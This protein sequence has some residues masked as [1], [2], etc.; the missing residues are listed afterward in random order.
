MDI[1]DSEILKV[2]KVICDNI[3]QKTVLGDELLSQNIISQ[4]RN[5]VEA[6]AIKIYSCTC[7]TSMAKEE[8][9]KALQYIKSQDR[10]TF[11]V[12]F[13]NCLQLTSSHTTMD[14]EASLRLMWKYWDYLYECRKFI[15]DEYNLEVLHNLDDFILQHD[16]TLKEYYGEIIKTLNIVPTV[17]ITESPTNR[18]YINKKKPVFLNGQR[19]YELTLLP[20]DDMMS[21]SDRIIAF[22]KLNV[23]DYYAVHLRFTE[24]KISVINREMTI[25]I[26][27]GFRVSVR[28][29]EFNNYFKIIGYMTNIET[30]NAE[31]R[32]LMKYM[33]L[34]GIN[35][36]EILDYSEDKFNN[37]QKQLL[38]GLR[39]TPIFIGL[40]KCREFK[41]RDGYFVLKYLLYRLNNQIIKDQYYF[42]RNNVL[43][44]LN[45]K[46]GCIP[47]DRMPFAFNLIAHPSAISDLY[48]CFDDNG[49]AHELLARAIKNNTEIHAKLYTK[50]MDLTRFNELNNLIDK[51]NSKLYD[52]HK[53]NSCLRLQDG[54]VYIEGYEK[55]TIDIIKRLTELAQKGI[56]GYTESVE[57]WLKNS[58]Y[59][60][61]SEEKLSVLKN[62]FTS[63]NVSLIYGSAGTG[64]STMINHISHFFRD[65][66]RLYLANTHAAVE[67]LRRNVIGDLDNFRTI[68]DCL[69]KEPVECDILFVDECSTVS[70]QDMIDLLK[71]VKFRLLVLVGDIYQIESIKFGNWFSIAR[72]YMPK[73]A[74]YELSYVHRSTD[75]RLKELWKSVRNLDGKMM[76]HLE[77]NNYCTRMNDSIFEKKGDDEI[78]L[79]LNYD[80]LYGINNINK[81]L[82][83]NNKGKSVQIGIEK[84]K[85]GDPIIFKETERFKNL[86]YNNL[87]GT[88][89][90]I[91]E[92]EKSVKFTTEIDKVLN[93]FNVGNV[94]VELERPIH[95]GKSVISFRIGKFVNVDD[96]DRSA[97]DIIPF[98]VAY[99]ISIHKAQGLEYDSVKIVISDEMDKL[100]THNIFYTAITRAKNQLKIY[101]S[102]STEK[103]I[104]QSMHFMF[105]KEDATI[106]AKKFG[107]KLVK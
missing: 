5:F 4:L 44:E 47:F 51:F 86:L 49:R 71:F 72:F 18:F 65:S 20:A 90:G 21:K 46:Y 28:P 43:S 104:L 82:Q 64:K 35:L 16:D 13:H 17:E 37:I 105:N 96:E 55:N 39:S 91:E 23:P 81:F 32:E 106:L 27:T 54:F 66:S 68:R 38:S 79:C 94:S 62:L 92:D 84:F 12:R 45:L 88:I 56:G 42:Q 74:V 102:E 3:A 99:A 67:N 19:Y 61:D 58:S 76:D 36:T 22:T 97:G 78:V 48:E 10:F 103:K 7:N 1:F 77:N 73:N 29:C 57:D 107:L 59:N 31:Y 8:R 2:D 89:V 98:K 33:T 11:L 26:I 69:S 50:A 40:K 41:N 53:P 30:S 95:K 75:N 85:V 101:W 83:D 6:I 9:K 34:T 93:E 70:N 15:K 100:I 63:S 52:K 14:P 60:I 80:G 87:K 24:S 25:N